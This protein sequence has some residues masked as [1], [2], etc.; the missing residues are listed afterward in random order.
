MAVTEPVDEQ[1]SWN[2]AVAIANI[3]TLLMML[4]HMTGELFWLDDPYRPQRTR[5]LEDND[6][7]GLSDEEQDE[8]RAA[9]IAAIQAWKAGRPLAIERPS[10]ELLLK[11]MA[12]SVGQ[13]VPDHYA[14]IIAH[15]LRQFDDK[16]DSAAAPEGFNVIIIGAG[17]SGICAAHH[18]QE[19]GI[20]YTILERNHAV[21]GTWLENH[22][23]G[24]GVDTPSYLYSFSFA[25]ADWSHYFSLR[26][27]LHGYLTR[28]ADDLEIASSTRFDTEVV[29]AGYDAH[30]QEWV[31]ETCSG[32][33][34]AASLRANVVI[35]AVGA[36][37][38]P[39]IPDI[40]GAASFAGAAA[41]T[42]RWPEGGID[43][44]GKRVA[45]VG[46]GASAMQLVPAIAEEVESVTVFQR[47][48]QWAAPFEKFKTPIPDP[49]RLLLSE[50]PVYHDWYRIRL[51][52]TF[53][54]VIHPVLQKD[55]EWEHP[56]RSISARNDRHRQYFTEYIKTELGD[57]DDLLDHVLPDYPPYG[58]R[59]LMDNRW[60]RTL[61]RDNVHLVPEAVGE[62]RS[63][64]IVTVSG[65]E[66]EADVLVW[67]TGFD[68][69]HFLAPME[70][71]GRSGTPLQERWGD[72]ARAYLGTVI[73]DVP[74]FF[75]L[76]GPNAQFGHGGSLITIMERQ[77]HYVMTVLDQMFTAGIGSVEID[78]E[79]HDAYN[80]RVDSAHENMVW[81]H[82]GMD[83][84]YR[85]SQGRVVAINPFRVVDFWAMTEQADL[86]EYQTEPM[87]DRTP[88]TL[89]R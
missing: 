51:S 2:D 3:P 36:F 67:A 37:N 19:A 72:D 46:T 54:D 14:P 70:I 80:E 71:I 29:S 15:D 34:S 45:V 76:Y 63:D 78:Q 53:N 50:V 57:R 31:V 16:T 88:A 18:L 40:P 1:A 8:I 32:D 49:I 77:M 17:V 30:T 35:S 60:F 28:V 85:N 65:D 87:A 38:K 58:K 89:V 42:A 55:P 66:H 44:A 47:S 21:G 7:G 52:W 82:P 6:T 27:E 43:L 79:V 41:H 86:N 11:M 39:T 33:G 61:T 62:I 75:C 64:R 83:N 48:P 84:Y 74:N 10:E 69:I 59:M 26:D 9:A 12:V 4:V 24:C 73:P 13:D 5:G 22:Y 68:V 25:R 23:P 56:D 20:E 81:T